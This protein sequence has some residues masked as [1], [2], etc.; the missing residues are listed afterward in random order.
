[1]VRAFLSMSLPQGQG[2]LEE[3][4]LNCQPFGYWMT[5]TS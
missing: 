2:E 5:F 1:M 3:L 4:D